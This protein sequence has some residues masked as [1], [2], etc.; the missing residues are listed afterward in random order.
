MFWGS[1]TP[2]VLQNT[3]QN[4]NWAK[5]K[6]PLQDIFK[7]IF[8]FFLVQVVCKDFCFVLNLWN[9]PAHSV[10]WGDYFGQ[11][12]TFFY[13]QIYTSLRPDGQSLLKL[14]GHEEATLL[15]S[16]S[17]LGDTDP[18]FS[19]SLQTDSRASIVTMIMHFCPFQ[20]FIGIFVRGRK[21]GGIRWTQYYMRIHYHS[22]FQTMCLGIV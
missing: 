1:K 12:W 10:S 18:T 16:F 17:P 22:I 9:T 20:Y 21:R 13:S 19:Y 4:S 3:Q 2:G 8:F 15:L 11:C 5:S 6:R 7:P 14:I